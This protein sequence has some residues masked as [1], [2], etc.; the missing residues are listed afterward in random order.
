MKKIIANITIFTLILIS[1]LLAVPNTSN[2]VANWDLTGTYGIDYVCTSGCS[3]TYSH[4]LIVTAMDLVSGDFSGNGFYNSNPGYTWTAAGNVNGSDFTMNLVYTGINAGYTVDLVGTIAG[5]GSLSGTAVSSSGQTF[6]FSSASGNAAMI[7][8]MVYGGGQIIEQ[9]V[10]E[11]RTDWNKISFGGWAAKVNGSY[12]GEWEVNFHNV[13]NDN[14]DQSKFYSNDIRIINFYLP[15]S[16]TCNAAVNFTAFGEWNG[17]P[18]YK[19]IFRAGDADSPGHFTDSAFDT[20]RVEL[21][22]GSTKEYDT[23]T[24]GDYLNQSTCVGGN[25]TGLDN[26]NLTIINP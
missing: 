26:G 18:G 19:M 22:Y 20:A 8:G 17:I 13:G 21:Y 4:T 25:R 14:F 2:A 7:E 23:S 10:G 16:D 3:G 6:T 1:A 11:K 12:V 9:I 24:S 15:S 5:D